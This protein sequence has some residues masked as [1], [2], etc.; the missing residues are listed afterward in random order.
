MIRPTSRVAVIVVVVLPL[1]A[2]AQP[3]DQTDDLATLRSQI[4]WGTSVNPDRVGVWTEGGYNGGDHRAEVDAT[5]EA[6]V[7]PHASVFA[8]SQ[9][10]GEYVYNNPRP[11]IGA[12]YQI[13][14]PR[15]G[16]N[17]ARISVAYKPEGLTEPE[18]ELESV[19]VLSR[20]IHADTARLRVAY[21]QDPEGRESDAEGG[22]SYMHL[23]SNHIVVGAS[24]R[25]R[26]AIKVKTNLE[27]RWDFIGGGVAGYVAGR[28]RLEVM[29]GVDSIAY[30]PSPAQTGVVGLVSVGTEL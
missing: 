10:G 24:A 7:L 8:T 13:I 30:A 26:H 29:L 27:P 21:G 14:D 6:T 3:L 15:S 2:A 11:S 9:F 17:G 16:P 4:A 23:A 12:A 1:A 25:Y 28:S 20:R 5:V 18:G 19:L 22:G